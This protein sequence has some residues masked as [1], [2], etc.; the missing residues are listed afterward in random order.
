MTV[1]TSA[2]L[3]PASAL[4]R[5]DARALGRALAPWELGCASLRWSI[6][7]RSSLRLGHERGL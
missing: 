4:R 5:L 2:I 3:C 6:E 7:I 1:E